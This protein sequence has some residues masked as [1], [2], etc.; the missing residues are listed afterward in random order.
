M[1]E[2]EDRLVIDVVALIDVLASKPILMSRTATA[3]L[4]P[5]GHLNLL[6]EGVVGYRG[7]CTWPCKL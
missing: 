3:Y 6:A 2:G 7:H 4:L 5:I 1:I